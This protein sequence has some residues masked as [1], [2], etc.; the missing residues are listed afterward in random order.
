MR[1]TLAALVVIVLALPA[2][3]G[4]QELRRITLPDG[5]TFVG[6]VM[7][8]SASGQEQ[9]NPAGTIVIPFE[10]APDIAPATAAEMEQQPP[11]WIVV[12][13]SKSPPDLEERA[14]E[15]KQNL[16]DRLRAIPH[17]R[18]T[19]SS[20]LP[21]DRR[22]ALAEC[23]QSV[24]CMINA[25][26]GT[27]VYH[28]VVSFVEADP[29]GVRQR[30]I[31][32]DVAGGAERARGDMLFEGPPEAHANALLREGYRVLGVVPQV[33]IPDD[34]PAVEVLATTDG[35]AGQGDGQTDGSDEPDG[36]DLIGDGSPWAGDRTG[37]G[38]GVTTSPTAVSIQHSD[39]ERRHRAAIGLGFLPF[40]GLGSAHLR[41]PGG[42]AVNFVLDVGAGAGLVYL[43]GDIS[44]TAL[45]FYLPA[46]LTTYGAGVLINQISVAISYK[47]L[48]GRLPTARA[49]VTPY[50]TVLPPAGDEDGPMVGFG[51]SVTR[52]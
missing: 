52:F 21:A 6:E 37:S 2:M 50:A 48:K 39:L 44:P 49:R 5:Q 28:G 51:L 33:A 4:A 3:A 32:L 25:L 23:G 47:R 26:E 11:L 43:F 29:A 17:T 8:T 12:L 16:L 1:T 40:P 15:L 36:A 10:R 7:G 24:G 20:V 42:F 9:R 13:E 27:G 22:T 38:A 46:I 45:G 35:T 19:D 30:L 14:A 31:S 34:A 18:V 41:D